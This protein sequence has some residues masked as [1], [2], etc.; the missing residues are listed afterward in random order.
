MA[1]RSSWRNWAG[2]QQ[3]APERID[4]PSSEAE[5]SRIVREAAAAGQRVKVAGSG[6]SFTGIAL[7][8]GRLLRLDDYG[9]VLGVDAER[10]TVTVQAG[11]KLSTLNAEL[12]ARGLAL[13]NLGDVQ[14]Q[15][16]SGAVATS[17]HGTGIAFNGIATQI[18]GM[19]LVAGD[20]SVIECSAGAEP[21][22]FHAARVGLGA[23]GLVSTLTLQCVPAFRMRA[24]EEPMRLDE[25]LDGL[26]SFVREN[27]HFEFYYVPHTP[28]CFVKRNNRTDQ[29]LAP[30][31]RPREFFDDVLVQNVAFEALCRLA[32]LR[33]AL[34]PRLAKVVAG[35][36]RTEYVDRAYK[37][38]TS[39]RLV[40]F[41]EMEYAIPRGAAAEALTRVREAIDG[42]GLRII[43]PI[44]VRFLAGDD[45]PLSTAYGRETCYIAVH[46]YAGTQYQQ[47]FEA[48]ESIMNDYEG[49]PHWGKLHFQNA[50]T[51]A[52]RY[53]EWNRFQTVRA[54]LDPEG[55]FSN[56]YLDRVLGP[57]GALTAGERP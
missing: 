32:R 16:I 18:A 50:E 47:Y 20:G 28:W 51:L 24:V 43:F 2:N 52:R 39:P 19:R 55:R 40:R 7:T 42:S 56:T 46:V 31:S 17:T 30:R 25:V 4:R 6:H 57:V 54:R 21:E 38:F 12:E 9:S 35:S 11:I 37:V 23:L 13:P 26:D 1:A 48:V 5:L 3:C 14:Y 33:P 27:D 22:V 44:E 45:I 53:P 29:P 34:I 8:D 15:T 41:Y 36:V 49:R 10:G